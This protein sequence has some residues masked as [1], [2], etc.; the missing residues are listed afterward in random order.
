VSDVAVPSALDGA[1]VDRAI[2]ELYDLPVNAVRRLLLVDRVRVDGRRVKKG[3]SVRAGSTIRLEGHGAWLVPSSAHAVP[4]LYVDEHVIVVDKPAGMPCHPLVPGEG[5]SVVDALVAHFADIAVASED[6]REGGLVHR[7]DTGTSGCLAVARDRATWTALRSAFRDGAVGK[8]YL[9]LV[10]GAVSHALV[11]DDAL[12]HDPADPRRMVALAGGQRA[13]THVTPLSVTPSHSL[14]EVRADGGR[15][16]QV[17][18]HLAIAGH[19]LV[20]DVLY[21][22]AQQ[23]ETPWHLLH[24]SSL[25]VPGLRSVTAPVPSM[26]ARLAERRG[27]VVPE[28]AI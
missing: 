20:G 22:A 24:A 21:G 2:A 17:R 12:G 8:T 1:R 25:Q 13:T 14:V 19:P 7:L 10:E 28:G 18:V 15:R 6:P 27:L 26:F 3:D 16:H 5:G 11:I 4:Q 9:A 23:E